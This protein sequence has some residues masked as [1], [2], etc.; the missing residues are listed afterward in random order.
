MKRDGIRLKVLTGDSEV[1]TRHVCEQVGLEVSDIILGEEIAK[2][3]DA[4]LG[5]LMEK[6]TV[7]ARVSP[8]QKAVSF[9]P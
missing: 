2:T 3:T 6:Y 9:G 8:A 7:F 5:H 4:P 1:V